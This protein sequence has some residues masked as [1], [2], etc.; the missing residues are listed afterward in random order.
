MV[1]KFFFVFKIISII[2]IAGSC[3]RDELQKMT[4]D[5]IKED[6]LGIIV[7]IP[8]SKSDR[9]RCFMIK[10]IEDNNLNLKSIFQNYIKL[11]P[12]N[13][14]NKRLFLNY[15]N[16]KCTVHPIGVNA[17]TKVPSDIAKYLNLPNPEHYTGHCFRRSSGILIS[18]MSKGD[19]LKNHDNCTSSTI[20]EDSEEQF[21]PIDSKINIADQIFQYQML[22]QMAI[23]SEQPGI[24]GTYRNVSTLL[25][26]PINACDS[27]N[28]SVKRINYT[29][30]TFN[31]NI[32]PN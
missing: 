12:E 6:A 9:E 1:H 17:I 23:D 22:D 5:D 8:K 11:R 26:I 27:G 3:R 21:E 31:I 30:C 25:E 19:N 18:D 32:V 20:D 15:R 2:G 24:S 16:G 10:G 28:S 4:I 13:I 14:P 7:N 29:N